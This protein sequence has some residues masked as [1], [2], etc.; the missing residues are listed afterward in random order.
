MAIY[1]PRIKDPV[2]VAAVFASLRAN[3]TPSK[4]AEKPEVARPKDE[5]LDSEPYRRLVAS[6]P[7]KNCGRQ[8]A[9][10]AAHLPPEGKG[11]K[12]TDL[13]TFALCIAL[14]SRKKPAPGCHELFDNY[15]LGDHA[16]TVKQGKAWAA[17]TRREL[18]EADLL[19]PKL[20]A[21][22]RAYKPKKLRK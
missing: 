1:M 20:A 11:I 4:K 9:S 3:D 13:E 18:L 17:E 22:V 16:W 8:K 12:V 5:I 2:S 15:K 14:T 7:C 21:A 19:P 10:Q 6:M